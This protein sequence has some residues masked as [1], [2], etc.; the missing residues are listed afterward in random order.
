M[1]YSILD[2]IGNTPMVEIKR[3][4]PNPRVRILAK[5]EYFNPGGSVKDRPALRMI[6]AG[7]R[8][9]ELV[10]GKTVVEATSGNTGIG[11]ALVCAVRGYKLLLTMSEAVS[12]ERQK[13]L[14]ARGADIHLTPGHLGTDGAIEEVYRMAREYPDAYFMTDQYNNDANWEAHYYGTAPEIWE[15]TKGEITTFVATMG[16]S[17]TLMG[18][19]RR[20]KEYNPDIRIVGVEP[21]L[22]HKIQ[23]LKNM[24]EAYVPDLFRKKLLDEKVNIEDEEA[25]E[26]TRRLAREEGLFVGMSSGAAMAIALKEAENMAEGTVVVLLPDSG[27]R[28]LST[29]VFTVRDN[30][31]LK[32]F[33]TVSREKELFVPASQGKVSIYS[34]GPTVYRRMNLSE[35]RRFVFADLLC[36]YLEYRGM[37]V[38]HVVNITDLDDKTIKGSEKEK[39][40]LKAFTDRHTET[41]KSD[42]ASLC[43]KPA[44]RY[45]RV[46]EHVDDMVRLAETLVEKGAAYEKLRS[47]YFDIGAFPEYG[48]LSGVDLDKIRVGATVDLDE[49][50]KE[51]PRDFTLFKRS[52]LSE[53]KRGVCIKTSWGNVRPSLHLQCAAISMKYLGANFDIHTSGRELLFPHHENEIAIAKAATG[54]DLARYWAH[55]DRVHYG[56]KTAAENGEGLTLG[57]VEE[58]G[59]TAR[60]VRYW[61]LSA[62]YRKPVTFSDERMA[63]TARALKKIDAC[64]LALAAVKG[65]QECPKLDQVLYDLKSG[66]IAA[67]DDDMNISTAAAILFR[68]V[69]ELNVLMVEEMIGFTGAQRAID[70][71][72]GIDA[73]LQVFD[74]RDPASDPDVQKI[75][76]E[77]EEARLAGDWERA[78]GLRQRLRKQGIHLQDGK[79]EK[80]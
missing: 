43:V 31:D 6:D 51:N 80:K 38:N 50:E 21:Y 54:N 36:R 15:Q 20:F 25:F 40:G 13:I 61:L 79:Y 8:S 68:C 17:G 41:F 52:K 44:A 11:L 7:E 78:D 35:C 72:R 23:G 70:A 37:S 34:C 39:T 1:S 24:R 12:V 55:C 56:G 76:R 67:M 58:M 4:N 47:L 64:L 66:F 62:H 49:Y 46:S 71:F 74:F 9:G 77:R 16:T 73:V 30:L 10:H 22:G 19:S 29:P 32:L 63:E 14:K 57:D 75:I 45:A 26:M 60:E 18:A 59:W 69:K 5:L 33:N 42:L 28:Y 27:E 48:K 65:G 3:M 2:A 53:L